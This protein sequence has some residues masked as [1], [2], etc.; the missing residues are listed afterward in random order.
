MLWNTDL[1]PAIFYHFRSIERK[2]VRSHMRPQDCR[3]VVST[4]SGLAPVS[5][6][7]EPISHLTRE[8]VAVNNAFRF[9]L[10]PAGATI[11]GYRTCTV[12]WRRAI[13]NPSQHTHSSRNIPAARGQTRPTMDLIDASTSCVQ[14]V[15]NCILIFG[16]ARI[17]FDHTERRGETWLRLPIHSRYTTNW[18]PGFQIQ[19]EQ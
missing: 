18:V 4:A 13:I 17:G 16:S 15:P 10:V 12:G 3:T 8:L 7:R 19:W 9:G 6:S 1:L 11:D 14:E 5:G 2:R